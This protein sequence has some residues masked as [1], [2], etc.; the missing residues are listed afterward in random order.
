MSRIQPPAPATAAAAAAAAVSPFTPGSIGANGP[1]VGVNLYAV[2]NY[3]AA[4]TTTDA[5]RTLSYIKNDLRAGAV[6]IAWNFYNPTP[7]ASNVVTSK[8]TTLTAADVAIITKLAISTYHLQV[9]YRPMMFVQKDTHWAGTINPEKPAAWF[10]SFYQANLPYLKVAQRYHISEYVMATEMVDLTSQDNLW[11]ALFARSAKTYKGQI[12]VT[13]HQAYY[14]PPHFKVPATRLTGFDFYES[15]KL[16]PTAPLKEVVAD[17]EKF[18]DK[19]PATQLR[20]TAIQET[21]IAA[22]DGAY[23][24]PS[25]LGLT[26]TI[27]QAVQYNWII[28]GCDAVHKFDLRGIFFWK[29]DLADRPLR[30]AHNPGNFEGR[31]GATAIAAC[32]SILHPR[33]AKKGGKK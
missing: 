17:Y 10:A 31:T 3:S 26:G 7:T 30:P 9:E 32:T 18:F 1:V 21:G 20:R 24:N 19:T 5:K 2:D 16:P 33:P 4:Q 27:N 15:L 14:F 6:D 29:V 8:A 13:A 12:S 11:A 28:A 22:V 25:N 23:Q